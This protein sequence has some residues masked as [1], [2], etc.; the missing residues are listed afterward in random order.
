M[1]AISASVSAFAG[2][3]VCQAPQIRAKAPKAVVIRASAQNDAASKAVSLFAAGAVALSATPVL[4]L[5][6]IE[7]TDKRVEQVSGLQL[8]YEARDLD[9][10]EKTRNDGPS[11]FALQKLST[12]QTAARASESVSRLN[13]DV[14]EYIGK[15]YWTQASN[16]LRRQVYTLRFD[17]NNLVEAKGGSPAD[18]KAFYKTLESLDFAIRKKDQAGATSL[19]GE[20]Q[21]DANALLKAL[22]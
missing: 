2:K 11:R 5:N 9:L 17:I 1:A 12:E 18:A 20:V 19:L 21:N 7:L 15:K 16:E 10:D 13:K 6:N 3:A 8:I 4:A 14:S 22:A